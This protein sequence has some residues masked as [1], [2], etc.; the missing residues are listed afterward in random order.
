MKAIVLNAGYGGRLRPTTNGL[1]KCLFPVDADHTVLE[2][3]LRTLARCG[4]R[5]VTIMVGY[6]AEKIEHF[7]ATHT[8]AS[9]TVQ[10]RYN[11]FFA[12]TNTAVTCWLAIRDMT[13]DFVLLNGD[14]LFDSEI[15]RRL[16][17]AP[18]APLVMAIDQKPSYDTDDMK[19]LLTTSGQLK[20]VGKSLPASQIDGE[21][22]GLMTFRADGI[23]AFRSALD[24]TVRDPEALRLWYHD[25]ISVMA[26]T[27]PVNTVLIEGLWWREID[28]PEDLAEVRASFARRE[29]TA[30][31]RHS[32]KIDTVPLKV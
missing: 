8:I 12:T 25:V 21:S 6:E 27:V 3:Q 19:V 2:V 16:L 22:I 28:T 10:T 4:I 11:P 26:S 31:V 29:F 13:E 24:M 23:A 18:Q 30:G 9:L 20:A 32:S 14:T 15:L 17:A 7:L 5:H 1:P